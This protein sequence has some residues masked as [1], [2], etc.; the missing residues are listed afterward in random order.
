VHAAKPH[1]KTPKH[2]VLKRL[3]LNNHNSHLYKILNTAY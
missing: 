3:Y 2:V 1:Q